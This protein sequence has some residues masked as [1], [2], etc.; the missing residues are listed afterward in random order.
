MATLRTV[1]L[2]AA[3][4]LLPVVGT[5]SAEASAPPPASAA[6]PVAAHPAASASRGTSVRLALPRPTGPFAVGRDTLHLV[7]RHRRDPWVPGVARELMVDVYYP[8]RAATGTPARYATTEEIRRYLAA[9]GLADALPVQALADT[10]VASRVGARPLPGRRALVLLS[11]GL[12]VGR[13]S[14]TGLAEDLASRGLVAAT[15][16]HAY[17][18]VGT[19]FPG[20]RMLTCVACDRLRTDADF[21]AASRGRATDLSFVLDSLTG[22]HPA[23]R[24][25]A[26]IDATRVAAVGHSLGGSAAASLLRRDRRVRA[27]VDLDGTLGE[28][29]GAGGFGE[30]AFLL[31]GATADHPGSGAPATADDDPSWAQA[32]A[33]LGPPRLWLDVDGADHFSFTD[34]PVLADQIPLPATVQ[35][36]AQTLTGRQAL[37]ITRAYV[38]A[39]VERWL[40]G[41]AQPLLDGPSR[42]YPQVRVVGR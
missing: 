38:G 11:P 4:L 7:N 15:V 30:R 41:R 8:A 6:P 31:L 29:V 16:D 9:L 2:A 14:L 33:R 23:W 42:T 36:P 24:G 40:T 17:E 28:P 22:P 26:I 34:D 39:F 25:A 27:G 35:A 32:W 13:R 3:I 1:S 12:G 18:S 5:R 21:R 19:V 10:A 37:A 20:G